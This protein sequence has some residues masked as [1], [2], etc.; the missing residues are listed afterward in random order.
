MGLSIPLLLYAGPFPI[1]LAFFALGVY[2]GGMQRRDYK[3][4]PFILMLFLGIILSFL[5]AKYLYS[6]HQG[7]LGIKLWAHFYSF[8]VIMLL[9]SAKMEKLCSKENIFY[10][11]VTKI[12][13][14]SFGIYLIHCYFILLLHTV[15]VELYW[16][17]SI[18]VVLV[19]AVL[20][21]LVVQRL[22]SRL[23]VYLGFK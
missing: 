9:F 22:F 20:F 4:W 5:E 11:S 17:I 15:H 13:I 23:I 10:K 2:L 16:P 6:F 8:A 3:L 19:L 12:G 1:W 14:L 21:I 7:G 18:L